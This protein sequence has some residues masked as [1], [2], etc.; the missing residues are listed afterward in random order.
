MKFKSLVSQIGKPVT[1]Q[2]SLMGRSSKWV[3]ERFGVSR[4]TAQRWKAGAQQPSTRGGRRERVMKS[5]DAETRRKIAA[6][7]LRNA[8]AVNAGKV[9]VKYPGGRVGGG[10]KR[11]LG[12]VQLGEQG[13]AR[14][15]EAADAL[16]A[17]DTQG[18]ERAV[19]DALLRSDNR[20]YGPLEVADW[21]AGFH[22]I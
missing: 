14:M 18:A 22:L 3:A 21:P 11:N 13:R 15:R 17:G 7:A 5:A 20:N 6:D 4:R 12:V 8:E 2:E 16:E 1:V 19:S 10:N 9:E